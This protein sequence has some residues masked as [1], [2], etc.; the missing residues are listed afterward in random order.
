MLRQGNRIAPGGR[1][2]GAGRKPGVPNKLSADIKNMILN[3][4]SDVG[5]EQYLA[6]RAR[7]CPIAF[8]SLL[9]K[10]LP[11]Q[12]ASENGGALLVDF[13]W[14]DETPAGNGAQHVHR[15]ALTINGEAATAAV[16][17][18]NGHAAGNE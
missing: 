5:G 15:H 3:A 1:R 11:M 14:Q 6:A 2:E 12:I 17:T 4:L 16:A 10:V 13:R 7:D 8:L 18:I 9:G